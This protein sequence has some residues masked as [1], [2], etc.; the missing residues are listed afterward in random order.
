MKQKF[1]GDT[2]TEKK[3]INSIL[4]FYELASLS[5]IQDGLTWYA[6][7]NKYAKELGKRFNLSIQQVAGLI[8]VFS[9]QAGWVENKRYTVSFLYQPNIRVRSQVQTNKAK[10][11]LKLNNEAD[12]YNAQSTQDK[13]FKTKAFFKNILNPDLDDSVT[14]D[15][16]AIASCIQHPDNVSALDQSYG[17]LTAQQYEF[18]QS[19]YIKAAR[20]VNVLPHQLQAIVWVTYRRIRKLREHDTKTQW[21]PFTTTEA[22]PF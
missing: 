17:Q 12:I 15:R 5:E 7:A 16:H 1:K 3:C 18:F 21:Q 8:A 4:R 10:S 19:C 20:Q 22:N 13:A 14:I 11:I 6:E 9:P 2:L